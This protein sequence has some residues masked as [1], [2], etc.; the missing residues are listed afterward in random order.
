MAAEEEM[1]T[2]S[3]EEIEGEEGLRRIRKA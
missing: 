2:F 3:D 1:E